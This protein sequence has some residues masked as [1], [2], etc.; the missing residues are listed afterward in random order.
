MERG[1][2]IKERTMTT[3]TNTSGMSEIRELADDELDAV[4]G[5]KEFGAASPQLSGSNDMG[6]GGGAGKVTVNPF[7]ITR[8]ID[9]SSPILF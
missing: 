1:I 8:K 7:S 5:G 2:T 9:S 3:N 4:N 6:G